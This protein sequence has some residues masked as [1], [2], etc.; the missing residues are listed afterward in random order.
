LKP[1]ALGFLFCL[2]AA[3]ACHSPEVRMP[4]AEPP[5]ALEP[6]WQDALPAA[7]EL[8]LFLRPK[9]LRA[10]RVY[11]PMLR[12]ALQLARERRVTSGSLVLEAIED[13]DEAVAELGDWSATEVPS[14]SGELVF[15]IQGT[16]AD[17]DPARLVGPE[18][19]LLWSAGPSGRV[20]ELVHE[21]DQDG[22]PNP[23]SLFELADRT[24]VVASGAARDRA[25]EAFAHPSRR[26]APPF[27]T[28]ALAA[29]TIDG[30]SLV[31]KVPFLQ[32]SGPL[33]SLGRDLRSVELEL[34]QPVPPP[35]GAVG[36]TADP[37]SA[38]QIR[39]LLSYVD[40]R[41]AVL[42]GSAMREILQVV[43]RVKPAGLSWLVAD[44]VEITGRS[45]VIAEPVP[46][47]LLQRLFYSGGATAA[48]PS[49]PR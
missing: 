5:L 22:T 44:H 15:V 27:A 26:S 34:L 37:I 29:V 1:P 4:T 42:A 30:P 8:L 19:D 18:G 25:R 28:D 41:A 13:A 9:A 48:P 21:R 36:P 23:A 33:A 3:I 17:L 31:A 2:P 14:A 43:S 46:M 12:Q 10:D 45:V 39:A 24:W 20:R 35:P 38:R 7:P 32:A 47:D 49:P 40:D 16:R 11:G 6:H